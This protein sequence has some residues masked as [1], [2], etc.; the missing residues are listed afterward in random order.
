[1]REALGSSMLFNLIMI[2]T[3]VF[4]ALL[5]GSLAYSK[6]FKVRNRIIDI[7]EKHDGYTQEAIEE[8]N[9]NLATIG[10][11]NVGAD[12]RCGPH[13]GI[14]ALENTSPY[15]YCIYRYMTSKGEYYGVTVYVHFDIPIVGYFLNFP[16]YGE[17]RILFDKNEV[18]G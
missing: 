16:L 1:M 6:G 9:E 18:E 13:N 10:Y 5:I 11:K 12:N 3:A 4:I 14:D 15:D 17:T 7:V 8:I 2:F